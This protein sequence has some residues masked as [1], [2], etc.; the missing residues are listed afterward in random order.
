MNILTPAIERVHHLGY[1]AQLDSH[2]TV[3]GV[4]I[5]CYQQAKGQYPES[6]NELVDC[7]YLK[8]VPVDPWSNKPLV[9]RRSQDSFL[10]YSVGRNFTDDGGVPGRDKNG[11]VRLLA[12]DGDAVF[13]PVQ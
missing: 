5:I 1:R 9:Y 4:A 6:L 11:R 13:W 12:D 3:A 10:L 8:Q 7:G 2:A